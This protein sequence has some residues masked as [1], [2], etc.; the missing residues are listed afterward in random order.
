MTSPL[1]VVSFQW[2]AIALLIC[3]ALVSFTKLLEPPLHCTFAS[4]S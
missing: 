2:P 1:V 3:K 4:N